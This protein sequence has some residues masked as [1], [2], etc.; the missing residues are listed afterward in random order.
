MSLMYLTSLETLVISQNTAGQEQ[1]VTGLT[2]TIPAAFQY[3]T[4]LT[5]LT[6]ENTRVSG[7]IPAGLSSLPDLET[8]NLQN[9]DLAGPIPTTFTNFDKLNDLQLQN[10][11]L[12]G[13]LPNDWCADPPTTCRLVDPISTT[14]SFDCDTL[15]AGGVGPCNV[16]TSTCPYPT[17]EPTL[18][19]PTPGPTATPAPSPVPTYPPT[20][21][22]SMTPTPYPSYMP[23][24]LPSTFSPTTGQPSVSAVPT[25]SAV[26]TVTFRPT[27]K[28]IY[29]G[30]GQTEDEVPMWAVYLVGAGGVVAVLIIG[31]LGFK[32]G[33]DYKEEKRR[34]LLD[35][36]GEEKFEDIKPAG[37]CGNMLFWK[38]DSLNEEK[39]ELPS[40]P[41]PALGKLL[42]KHQLTR[43]EKQLM[44]LGAYAPHSLLDLRDYHV[45]MMSLEAGEQTRLKE[46]LDELQKE[47]DEAAAA[48]KEKEEK[49]EAGESEAAAPPKPKADASNAKHVPEAEPPSAAKIISAEA[50]APKPFTPTGPD[51]FAA[52]LEESKEAA[53]EPTDPVANEEEPTD[54][55]ADETSPIL[56]TASPQGAAP[57]TD[58]SGVVLGL[59]GC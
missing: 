54:A 17:S 35:S 32:A 48:E 5:E 11:M 51:P 19:M 3:L 15:C 46:A 16:N 40:A 1:G 29:V 27:R 37:V 26:P 7:T 14:N 41:S 8:L 24:P 53:P 47:K 43:L 49:A 44:T 56:A 39:L 58:P 30:G 34:Q 20:P 4:A 38:D 45:E 22:P 52:V 2:G 59:F 36:Y 25:I 57:T 55:V 42:T 50:E 13:S 28:T 23:S 33:K 31:V 6:I 12:T 21:L 18:F 9:N 10:N